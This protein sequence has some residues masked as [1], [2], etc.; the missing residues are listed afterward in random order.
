MESEKI[1]NKSLITSEES[2]GSEH[3]Q[4]L[5]AHIKRLEKKL[6]EMKKVEDDLQ[7]SEKRLIRAELASKSGNWEL[8]LDTGQMVGSAGA[9][10]IYGLHSSSLEYS[11][12]KDFPL[13]EYRQMMDDAINDLI[14]HN[15]PYNIEFKIRKAD[16][17]E[18][19][20]IH[21]IS[22]F[23]RENRILFGIIQDITDRKKA[24]EAVKRNNRDLALLLDITLDL[25]ET[26]ER[27]EVF[28]KIVDGATKLISLDS[29]AIYFING[30]D[31]YLEATVPPLPEEFPEEFRKAFLYNHPHINKAVSTN[32]SVVI[33]DIKSEKLTGEEKAIVEARDLGSV[34]YVPISAHKQVTGTLIL[35]TSGRQHS[36][37]EREIDLAR[38]F[39]NIAS[40]ALENSLLFEKLNAKV[41]ELKEVIKEKNIASES[42]KKSEER[43]RNIFNNVQDV[44]YQT[45]ING[46]IREISPSVERFSGFRSDEL[47]NSPVVELYYDLKDREVLLKE[48]YEHGEVHDYELRLKTKN[49]DKRIVSVNARLVKDPNGMPDHIDGAIRDITERME[50]FEKLIVAKEKAEESD[51]LKT[52][53]LHNI[54]HEIRT[55]LNAIIGFSGFLDQPDLTPEAR[56]EYID[57]IFQ[58]NNQLLSI[59]NDILSVSHIETGQITVNKSAT[60]LPRIMEELYRRYK[61]EAERKNLEFRMYSGLSG[62]DGVIVSDE[63]KLIQ[64]ISNLLSNALK[65]T[66][67]GFIEFGFRK[68]ENNIEIYVEDT[69][70]GISEEEH[71]KIFDRFYQVDKSIDRIYTGT[72]LGLTISNAYVKLLGGKFSTNSICGKGSVFSFTIP[73]SREEI[74]AEPEKESLLQKGPAI[75]NTK[76]LLVAEDEESNYALILAM[77]ASFNYNIIWATDGQ[78]AIDMCKSNPDI[79]LILMDIKMPVKNGFEATSEILQIKPGIP[80]IA[81]TAYAH[82]YDRAKALECGCTDYIAKPFDKKQLLSVIEKYT[83]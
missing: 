55:P 7:K 30:N 39:S 76:T 68:K 14:R 3:M 52:A 45:D 63:N 10:K 11:I 35:G 38:T 69:G 21:S 31:L 41:T 9:Q 83:R 42:L 64:I 17:G 20:D 34:L 80:I 40:L 26:V 51:Q 33:N 53:F 12:V 6:D 32:S 67:K 1:K 54:S 49:G 15:K 25:L 59:I 71:E 27:K 23:D 65:F 46:T 77:L 37:S 48:I 81:Q 29:G 62:S 75:K 47:I 82:P 74:K 72:G 78:E 57:I 18:V 43:Y 58:S 4:S 73:Y 8:H 70:I 16:T 5:E 61:P 66:H 13:P 28:L 36:F 56:K 60:D 2:K 22:E 19:I 50:L 79:S 24:E 44:F